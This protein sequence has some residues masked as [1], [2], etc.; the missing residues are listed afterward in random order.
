MSITESTLRYS[1]PEGWKSSKATSSD[2]RDAFPL[3]FQAFTSG[4][5][6][7]DAVSS[8]VSSWLPTPFLLRNSPVLPLGM[9]V[10]LWEI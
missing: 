6:G 1:I 3:E 9:S 5:D 2:R 7:C 8:S 4:M 10:G